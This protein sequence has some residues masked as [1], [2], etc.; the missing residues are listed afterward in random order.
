MSIHFKEPYE[1]YLALNGA[2]AEIYRPR[3]KQVEEY[4]ISK[5]GDALYQA[6]LLGIG[7]SAKYLRDNY[8][9][10]ILGEES[11]GNRKTVR[12]ELTPKSADARKQFPKLEIWV[13]TQT[14]QAVQQK[15]H[16]TG[17]EDYR[18]FTYNDIKL[19]PKLSDKVFK[20]D[21]PKST[22]RIRP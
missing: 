4:N 3:I 1:Y 22:K 14:W 10:R 6:F 2:K 13:S 5:H 9:L 15:L 17:G 12:M 16:Q 11:V 18:V 19:N 8:D 20:L 21:I 7:T